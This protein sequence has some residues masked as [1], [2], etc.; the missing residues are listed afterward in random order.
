MIYLE[1]AVH[2]RFAQLSRSID[3]IPIVRTRGE[4]AG[5]RQG[6]DQQTLP[7]PVPSKVEVGRRSLI[8]GDQA[9][10]GLG[11]A[12]HEEDRHRIR[13][14]FRLGPVLLVKVKLV[15][16]LGEVAIGGC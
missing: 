15:R 5:N 1:G 14:G 6:R 3:E 2:G 13:N 16:L 4:A 7:L 12:L 10:T 8:R 11:D 9:A